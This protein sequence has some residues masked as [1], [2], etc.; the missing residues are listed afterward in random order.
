MS[1]KLSIK[2]INR[3]IDIEKSKAIARY[4]RGFLPSEKRHLA[5]E[6][7]EQYARGLV[8]QGYAEKPK[9]LKKLEELSKNG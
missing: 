5:E 8:K 2:R 4:L 1:E 7:L 9:V 3:L 6:P